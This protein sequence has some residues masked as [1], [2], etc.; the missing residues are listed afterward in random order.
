[1]F[2]Q[3]NT[4]V[5]EKKVCS[6]CQQGQVS[7]EQFCPDC[8]GTGNGKRGGRGRCQRCYGKGR[9]WSWDHPATCHECNGQYENHEN[10]NETDYL[11]KEIWQS[12][13]FRVIRSQRGM[14]TGESLLGFGCVFSCTDYG[15]AWKRSDDEVIADV[16]SHNSTQASK[17]LKDGH[18]PEYIGIFVMP[19]GYS[20][21][22]VFSTAKETERELILENVALANGMFN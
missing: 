9:V 1:M 17:V 11:P 6:R 21:R 16:R 2:R 15:Q 7:T 4:I 12:L 19:G 3:G 14:T 20:V 5:M 13:E 10:E 18:L 22:P 8:K